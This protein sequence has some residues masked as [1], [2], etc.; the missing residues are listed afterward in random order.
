MRKKQT[1]FFAIIMSI[2]FIIH[3]IVLIMELIPRV[4]YPTSITI[5]IFNLLFL[6]E[7]VLVT[8]YWLLKHKNS[9][10]IIVF[11]LIL[12]IPT[13]LLFRLELSCSESYTSDADNYLKFDEENI[14]ME[15]SAYFPLQIEDKTIVN[16]SYFYETFNIVFYSGTNVEVCLEQKFDTFEY[17]AKQN[18]LLDQLNID[19]VNNFK[20]NQKYSEISIKDNLDYTTPTLMK[21]IAKKILFNEKEHSIIFVYIKI[22]DKINKNKLYYFN[23]IAINK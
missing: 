3:V 13:F 23:N 10:E 22:E 4:L 17:I 8:I 15:I 18:K 20:Y 14:N 1:I 7:V 5:N 19:T 21:G 16:Y 2:F 6:I 11:N 9:I 12:L